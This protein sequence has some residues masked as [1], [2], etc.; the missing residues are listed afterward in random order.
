MLRSVF[1]RSKPDEDEAGEAPAEFEA[2]DRSRKAGR[3]DIRE[4]AFENDAAAPGDINLA[5]RPFIVGWKRRVELA[6]ALVIQIGGPALKI[7]EKVGACCCQIDGCNHGE[8]SLVLNDG[9]RLILRQCAVSNCSM[10]CLPKWLFVS[11]ER[12]R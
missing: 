5:T 2:V 4:I 7:V 12:E 1:A 10:S 6:V 8:F 9:R 3:D 11:I